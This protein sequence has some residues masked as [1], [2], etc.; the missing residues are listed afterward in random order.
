MTI[1]PEMDTT[2]T[3]RGKDDHWVMKKN[4]HRDRVKQI[5]KPL[6]GRKTEHFGEI[7]VYSSTTEREIGREVL[8]GL[9]D[10]KPALDRLLARDPTVKDFVFDFV[11][12]PR[13]LIRIPTTASERRLAISALEKYVTEELRHQLSQTDFDLFQQHRLEPPDEAALPRIYA[14]MDKVIFQAAVE[15]GLIIFLV[16][17]IHQRVTDWSLEGEN[18]E[19]RF[20][21]LGKC[22]AQFSRVI[23]GAQ[24]APLAPRWVRSRSAIILEVKLLQKSLLL[25]FAMRHKL[26]PDRVLLDAAANI[27]DADPERFPKLSEIRAGLQL[28]VNAKPD[29]LRL[30]STGSLPPAPFTDQLIGWITNYKPESVA[31]LIRRLS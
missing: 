31:Q 30:L 15:Q 5:G 8:K 26:P 1:E 11:P 14:A 19:R 4:P 29:A 20:E 7:R 6:R 28:F 22:F 17:E 16:P 25:R 9:N 23:R 27:V 24:K 12:S 2:Q 13:T 21:E 18:G 10:L 3:N